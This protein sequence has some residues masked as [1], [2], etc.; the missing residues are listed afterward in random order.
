M[1]ITFLGVFAIGAILAAIGIVCSDL[2][3]AWIEKDY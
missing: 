3:H 1:L 2:F